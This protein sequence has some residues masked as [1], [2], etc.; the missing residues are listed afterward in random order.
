VETVTPVLVQVIDTSQLSPPIPDPSDLDFL[1][2]G[3]MLVSDGEV[4][5]IPSLYEG[6]NVFEVTTA[7]ELVDSFTTTGFSDEPAGLAVREETLFISDDDADAVF[8]VRTGPDGSWG[9][10][11]DR[12]SSFSTRPFGNN[13]PEGLAFGADVLFI[14]DGRDAE[15]YVVSRGRNRVFD[16]VPP[17]GDD[18]VKHFDTAVL[19]QP[20]PE[21]IEFNADSGTLF[22]VSNEGDSSIVETTLSG[23]LLTVIDLSALDIRSPAGLAYGPGSADPSVN[24]L[25]IADRGRDNGGDPTENDGKVFEIS[26]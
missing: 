19:D 9:T 21:D 24:D 1:P 4:E 18:R 20:D 15:V 6:K 14:T 8:K 23:G 13:D 2:S 5:E 7:G 17:I 16:G 22:I 3:N 11:D 26:F 12:V 10:K 25:Y